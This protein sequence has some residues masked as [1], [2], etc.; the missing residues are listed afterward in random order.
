MERSLIISSDGHAMALM[1]D[2]RPYLPADLREEFDGFL[3]L[4]DERG[5]GRRTF[6]QSTLSARCDPE[7]VEQWM[8]EVFN[9]LDG[10]HNPDRRLAELEREGIVG[11][12]LFPDFGLPF[13]L[14]PPSQMLLPANAG[15]P[16]RTPEQIR[17]GAWAHNRWLADFISVAPG[18]F[19]ALATVDWNDADYAVQELTWARNAGMRGVLLPA[20][21]SEEPLFHAR[22]ERVWDAI[23]DLGLVVNSHILMS[24]TLKTLPMV[25]AAPHPASI[26]AVNA[27][28]NTF[29]SQQTL[30]HLIWGGILEKH[31]RLRAAFTELGSGWI[32]GALSAMDYSYDGSYLRQDHR[33]LLKCKPSEYFTRQC[34]LGSSTFSRA[35]IAARHQIGLDK[36]MLGMDY[37]HHEGTLAAGGTTEYLRATLGAEGVPG[38]EARMLL[39]GTAMKLWDFDETELRVAADRVGPLMNEIL[40][41]P[42]EDL[43]PRGDVHKPLGALIQ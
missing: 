34:F 8:D 27:P 23:E 28:I 7:V 35:E 20:F 10:N 42:T 24:T 38:D 36:M 15:L 16:R 39:G 33:S 40:T 13:E 25:M 26:I 19:A 3:K 43:F 9:R 11:E 29:F 6:D 18:R 22:F 41:P 30:T 32:P 31:P 12:V 21:S 2:Y 5:R 4:Y 37:P 14:L 17:A 1:E